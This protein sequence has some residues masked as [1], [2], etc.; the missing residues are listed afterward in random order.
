M[1]SVQWRNQVSWFQGHLIKTIATHST[2][3]EIIKITFS[4]LLVNKVYRNF[5]TAENYS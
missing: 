3:D 2:Y 1:Y 4:L 5:L